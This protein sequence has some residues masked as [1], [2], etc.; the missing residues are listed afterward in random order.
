MYK[1]KKKKKKKLKFCF[2]INSLFYIIDIL[3]F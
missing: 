2:N 3:I 1:K